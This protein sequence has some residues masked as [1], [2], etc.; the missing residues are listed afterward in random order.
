[1]NGGGGAYLSMGTALQWP[2]DPPVAEWA[3]YPSREAV[4][5]KVELLTPRW[6]R[7]AWWWTD[8]YHAWPF[9]AEYLSALFDYNVAPFYQSF[10]EVRVEASRGRVR[11]VPYGINGR[12]RE[13]SRAPALTAATGG[14]EDLA[15]WV[16]PMPPRSRRP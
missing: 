2:A 1:V 12:L 7:P 13:L 8:R 14:D 15:E 4:V 10:M 9:S 3:Y 11:L 16:V 5:R 6:K